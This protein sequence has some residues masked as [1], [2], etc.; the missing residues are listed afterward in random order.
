M[1]C[2]IPKNRCARYT[3][4]VPVLPVLV[5]LSPVLI[6]LLLVFGLLLLPFGHCR[7][8]TD[9]DVLQHLNST[10]HNITAATTTT[11]TAAANNNNNNNNNSSNSKSSAPK[12]AANKT[13]ERRVRRSLQTCSQSLNLPPSSPHIEISST[14]DEGRLST[15]LDLHVFHDSTFQLGT[16]ATALGNCYRDVGG[17]FAGYLPNGSVVFWGLMLYKSMLDNH[18]INFF[19][20]LSFGCR[21]TCVVTTLSQLFGRFLAP[22]TGVTKDRILTTIKTIRVLRTK[23]ETI[24]SMTGRN[25]KENGSTNA[26][27]SAS[28]AQEWYYV[29][30]LMLLS[31]CVWLGR[32][33]IGVH[34]PLRSMSRPLRIRMV[35][36]M[37]RLIVEHRSLW[38]IRSRPGGL[39]ESSS[40]LERVRNEMR[41][42][43]T[44]EELMD[45][46]GGG[47]SLAAPLLTTG[48]ITPEK[49]RV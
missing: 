10:S 5:V 42:G 24:D 47:N 1:S 32:L 3:F 23:I 15:L 18:L 43:L 35:H 14:L 25:G 41:H 48:D 38:L 6:V 34:L 19:F 45:W 11:A 46:R 20:D 44:D 39:D 26:A 9:A 8:G 29:M 40:F 7:S 22:V 36:E 31:C 4:L 27:A 12:E 17:E 37:N 21:P 16:I 49:K 33:Q 30:D 13:K 2:C 28:S